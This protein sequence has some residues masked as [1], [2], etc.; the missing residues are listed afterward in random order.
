[1]FKMLATNTTNNRKDKW[2]A[3]NSDLK[4]RKQEIT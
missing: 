3:G 4:S 2:E 1:M